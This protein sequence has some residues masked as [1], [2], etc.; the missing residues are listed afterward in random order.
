MRPLTIIAVGALAIAVVALWKLHSPP[1][2][3]CT[4]N[5]LSSAASSDARLTAHVEARTCDEGLKSGLFVM[6]EKAS[7]PGTL[8]EAFYSSRRLSGAGLHWSGERELEITFPESLSAEERGYANQ[9]VAG[10][11][12]VKLKAP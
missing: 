1:V 12:A 10:I 8:Y 6:V 11:V 5:R 2:S 4:A 7:E 3:S 9:T